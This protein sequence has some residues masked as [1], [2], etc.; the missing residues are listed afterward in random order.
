M[1]KVAKRM[2]SKNHEKLR[3]QI[4]TYGGLRRFVEGS[5]VDIST[6]HRIVDGMPPDVR[7]V[8]FLEPKGFPLADWAEPPFGVERETT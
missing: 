4:G 8:L 3:A 1:A 6:W 2:N 7:I 5:G